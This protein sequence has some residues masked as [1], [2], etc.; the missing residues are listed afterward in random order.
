MKR[1]L[2]LLITALVAVTASAQF[3]DGYYR[4]QSKET[5]RYV[6]VHNSYVD[7]ESAKGT[8]QVE[9]YSLETIAG[10]DNIVN[11]PGSIIYL[12]STPSG[13]VIESQGFTTEGR[14]LYL[15]FTQ[16]DDAYLIWT[17]VT[18][19]GAEYTRYLRDCNEEDVNY[20]KNAILNQVKVKTI[21]VVPLGPVVG[22][23]SGPGTIIVNYKGKQ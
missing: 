7:T 11:D 22:A 8:G 5:G 18:Y 23:S 12:K 4:L 16:V 14:N 21:T 19:Q 9:L 20:F 17:T 15:Q 6:A 10:F 2:S 3:A 1:L 13:W